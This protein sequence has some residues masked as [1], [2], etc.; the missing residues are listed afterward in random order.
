MSTGLFI[1]VAAAVLFY[2]AAEHE[3]LNPL[4]WSV[5]SLGLTG[6]VV[7]RAGGLGPLLLAQAGLF[8]V[9][10]WYNVKRKGLG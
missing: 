2:R 3:R 9:L 10:W 7:L 1:G 4:L 6:I 8:L 5:A